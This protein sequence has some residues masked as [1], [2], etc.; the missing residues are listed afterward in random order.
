MPPSPTSPRVPYIDT[1]KG[2]AMIVI[3][4][5]HMVQIPAQNMY[6]S[7]FNLMLFTF[8]SGLF[9]NTNKHKD[10]AAYAMSKIRSLYIP[11]VFF[12]SILFIYWFFIEK[13][14]RSASIPWE[15]AATGLVWGT[16]C[17]YWLYPGGALW[18]LP[19][20]FSAELIAYPLLRYFKTIGIIV[21]T[22]A[23]FGVE[24]AITG[25]AKLHLVSP[26][27]LPM[28]MNSAL[29]LLPFLTGGYLLKDA[30]LTSGP[31]PISKWAALG[32]AAVLIA[33]NVALSPH[34]GEGFSLC[35]ARAG[36][37]WAYLLVPWL[38]IAS[39]LI[40]ARVIGSCSVLAA[41]G[42]N[43]LP[44]L[45]FHQPILRILRTVAAKL[46]GLDAVAVQLNWPIS[47]VIVLLA[48][49][50]CIPAVYAWRFIQPRL[51]QA[52]RIS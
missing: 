42:R 11:F 16:N 8:I 50:A 17:N 38:G 29:L 25:A 5:G 15:A 13:N 36:D 52:L 22:A 1:A 10:F 9:L 32:I 45:A 51:L 23:L 37:W 46:S 43:T 28:G 7:S 18:Y 47:Y 21:L 24:M 31:V 35:M 2:I 26:L 30:V 40:I 44:I 14:Y 12:Y 33:L 39:W 19:A 49:A 3:I 48:L 6:F 20:I 4:A 41:I 34:F 27:C